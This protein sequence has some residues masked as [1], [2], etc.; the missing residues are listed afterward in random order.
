M[1]RNNKLGITCFYL[2]F[3]VVIL[4]IF[5]LS[6]SMYKLLN[7]VYKYNNFKETNGTIV[8]YQ[9]NDDGNKAMIIEYSVDDVDYKL[10]SNY[11][12]EETYEVG[13]G[14]NVK[15]NYNDPKEYILGDEQLDFKSPIIGGFLAVAGIG[16]MMY[17]YDYKKKEKK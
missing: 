13:F 7:Y 1:S 11:S 10:I 5:I 3:I 9:I 6:F 4:G 16:S 8:G 15:Y 17:F 2:S 12:D 14:I